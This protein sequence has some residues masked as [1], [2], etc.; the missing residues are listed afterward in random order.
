MLFFEI[1]QHA[2]DVF[3]GADEVAFVIGASA[4]ILQFVQRTDFDAVGVSGNRT[5][6]ELAEN[7]VIAFVDNFE[8]FFAGTC[9][10]GAQFVPEYQ[11]SWESFLKGEI[12]NYFSNYTCFGKLWI[13]KYD[14]LR[15][16]HRSLHPD[17]YI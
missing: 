12:N 16:S 4:G 17:N 13:L 7:R 1:D 8:N 9:R 3:A 15:Q 14:L 11:R 2:F 10:A 6:F 5:D